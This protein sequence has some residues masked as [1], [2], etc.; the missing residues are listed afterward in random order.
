[1]KGIP[2]TFWGKLRRNSDGEE[3]LDWHPLI[4]HCIDVATYCRVVLDCCPTMRKRL[5][6]LGGLS[7]LSDQQCE[8]LSII[9]GV[10]DV[11]KY[12]IGFFNKALSKPPFAN[13]VCEVLSLFGS[14]FEDRLIESLDFKTM[15]KWA[16]DDVLSELLVVSFSHH[17]SPKVGSPFK[18]ILWKSNGEIDP[19]DGIAELINRF[20]ELFPTAW[21]TGGSLLPSTSSFR[22]AY[23]GL[24]TYADWICSDPNFFPFSDSD[25]FDIYASSSFNCAKDAIVKVGLDVESIRKK[26]KSYN[27]KI[28]FNT[29]SS[30]QLPRPAQNEI[31]KLPINY[32]GGISILEDSTGSGKT[33]VAII[34]WL[35]LWCEGEVD[36]LYFALPT[37]T[38]ATQIHSRIVKMV[39]YIFP[40]KTCRPAVTLAVPGYFLVDDCH[41]KCTSKFDV[42]WDDNEYQFKGWS[43]EN[44]KRYMFGSIVVGTIDQV[45]L[46]ALSVPH[47]FMRATA[48]LRHFIVIDE[49]HASDTYMNCILEEVLI[50][51][52]KAGGHALL[53]SATLG[54]VTRNRLI[55]PGT[56]GYNLSYNN[57]C[58]VQFPIIFNR[59]VGS[60]EV[61]EIG[62]RSEN[63]IKIKTS[64]LSISDD[65]EVAEKVLNAA[66]KGAKVGVIRNTVS[67]CIK[68]QQVLEQLVNYMNDKKLLMSYNNKFVPHHSRY[69]SGDR[70]ILDQ[71]IE[72]K[73][74]KDRP[75]GGCVVIATQTIQQSLD[76]DFDILFSDI[77]P[78]DILLQRLGRLYRHSRKN[79]PLTGRE[80]II[81]V[82]ENRD[83]SSLIGKDGRV[84]GSNG[85]GTVYEDLRIIEATLRSIESNSLF[86]LPEQCRTRV[87]ETTHPEALKKITEL[88]G[89]W[90]SHGNLL[91]EESSI[92]KRKALLN[93]VDWNDDICYPF[94]E[95]GGRILTRL[96]EGDLKVSF[97]YPYPISPF[98]NYVRELRLP[99]YMTMDIP[100][101]SC[102]DIK[103]NDNGLNFSLGKS[104]FIYDRLGLRK[105]RL[106]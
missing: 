6:S 25:N 12:N 84:Y 3:I 99:S 52:C 106:R 64:F 55:H 39:E 104:L 46:S 31:I 90:R 97:D 65:L 37:R 50:R 14:S 53:M 85:L 11:G 75:Q 15:C 38:S 5:A 17:G 100:I 79:R 54:S 89:L 94:S 33:E 80:V 8:R 72:S 58:K 57:A 36:G 28:T 92:N 49:V 19:F 29:V 105:V 10:H 74:G 34:R 83:L 60:S 91:G 48:L 77:C 4:Y 69:C 102:P 67:G 70:K 35:M 56:N 98:G 96:G 95:N 44:T 93:T 103:S 87:E 59:S 40:D 32:G 62:F 9:A 43:A 2:T 66:R 30:Y 101:D 23:S 45:L 27:N 86:I 71:V 42:L 18:P 73:F 63:N 21:T 24:I 22:Y 81:L 26:F 1:M 68:L 16:K 20:K 61:K 47:S 78:M 88:N 51:H 13:H 41:G 7:D 76:L 82:P